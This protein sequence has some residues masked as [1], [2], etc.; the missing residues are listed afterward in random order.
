[1]AIRQDMIA[2]H[3]GSVASNVPPDRSPQSPVRV[4]DETEDV[5]RTCQGLRR[6][7]RTDDALALLQQALRRRQL[8]PERIEA[9]GRFLRRALAEREDPSP[10]LRVLL[11][12]QCTT[13]WL[14]PVLAAEAWGRSAAVRVD[15]GG[16]DNVIQDLSGLTERPDVI[17]LLPWHQRLLAPDARAA[18]QRIDDEVAFVRQA[19]SMIGPLGAR[20]V[21]VGYDWVLPGPLG[22]QLGIRRDGTV[23]L[24]RQVNDAVM[25]ELSDGTYFVDLEQ[26]SAC[27]GHDAFYDARNYLWAKQP[28]SPR[29]VCRLSEHVWAGIRAVTTGP[30]KVLVLDLDNT[31]WGGVVGDV[32]PLGIQL[33]D[34]PDGEAYREFQRYAKG[35][36]ARGVVLAVCSKNNPPDAREPFERNRDMVL[37]LDDFASFE[38]SWDPKPVALERIGRTLR[39]GLDSFVFFDDS[40]AEREHVRQALPD[41][42][43]VEVP[44]DPADY[45]RALA[46]G[47]WFEAAEVTDADLQR[48]DQYRAEQQRRATRQATGSLDEYLESLRMTAEIRPIDEPDMQRVVQ[49]L[50]KTNQFNLTTRRHCAEDVRRILNQPGSLG[51]TL[52]LR[53]RFGD[54]GLISVVLGVPEPDAA[55]STLR[56]DTWLMSCRAIGRMIEDHLMNHVA[57]AVRGMGYQVLIGEFIPTAKNELV[58]DLYAR[59]GFQRLADNGDGTTRFE[60]KLASWERRPTFVAERT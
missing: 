21:L 34:S 33:G 3:A 22:H 15:E 13:S 11:L 31:L 29:G 38:A 12:G 14:A 37:T 52:R 17:V 58:A 36:S 16:Y 46:D 53:D 35:L 20:L 18:Q 56:L 9:A 49:L 6:D 23:R 1:M 42:E 54:Y 43:V 5:V 45:V 47:L 27:V 28:F 25:R 10:A 59:F 50:A 30:K 51:L 57:E 39:L 19:Q 40:P 55:V 24:V 44:P 32:G 60:L 7:G 48:S 26:V 41:V 8:E 2:E 4:A